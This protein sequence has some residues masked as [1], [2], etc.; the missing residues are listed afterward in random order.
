MLPSRHRVSPLSALLLA[1]PLLA[2]PPPPLF[3]LAKPGKF[4]FG[5]FPD[6]SHRAAPVPPVDDLA[7]AD[8]WLEQMLRIEGMKATGNRTRWQ[9]V[10]DLLRSEVARARRTAR[11]GEG[12][13]STPAPLVP[14]PDRLPLG[15]R[16]ELDGR[17][18][19]PF[20]GIVAFH[21]GHP[22]L[23]AAAT[24][25]MIG[26]LLLTGPSFGAGSGIHRGGS[27]IPQCF[28]LGGARDH[29]RRAI[30]ELEEALG[31][32]HPTLAVLLETTGM[33][34]AGRTLGRACRGAAKIPGFQEA[35][36]EGRRQ[37]VAWME[38]ALA[39]RQAGP[40][41][42]PERVLELYDALALFTLDPAEQ[43]RYVDARLRLLEDT[44]GPGSREILEYL[45][46]AARQEV[47]DHL[48][49]PLPPA[50]REHAFRR[51][52]GLLRDGDLPERERAEF[53][54]RLAESQVV[55]GP[56]G[57][58]DR[59]EPGESPGEDGREAT[60]RVTRLVRKAWALA[61]ARGDDR[62]PHASNVFYDLDGE[63]RIVRRRVLHGIFAALRGGEDPEFTEDLSRFYGRENHE[64]RRGPPYGGAWF[65]QVMA[66]RFGALI[67]L[68]HAEEAAA[69]RERWDEFCG[70]FYQVN[71]VV[72][73]EIPV[74]A[75]P[76]K[77]LTWTPPPPEPGRRRPEPPKRWPP[78][79]PP[80]PWA[81][82]LGDA[83]VVD[84]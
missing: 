29:F 20:S 12:W 60:R 48:G 49:A 30:R 2:A 77:V 32:E 83:P 38:R 4:L 69:V 23:R 14:L 24:R 46:R 43:G 53:L 6:A 76:R 75:R 51:A 59:P 13:I 44:H 8:R 72:R 68:G 71:L 84:G 5:T 54:I 70:N 78:L 61:G 74:E 34:L 19:V 50:V 21:A 15:P 73:N 82:D 63:G 79:D 26:H 40:S 80:E 55:Y 7:E 56:L 31:P 45:I 16:T 11:D 67:D 37:G 28:D 3:P 9:G 41:P 1:A 65:C 33:E 64:K 17:A 35:C 66:A 22:V 58:L 42:D 57:W 52:E 39:L 10:L 36:E 27:I 25:W 47:P 18:G 62:T 81:C